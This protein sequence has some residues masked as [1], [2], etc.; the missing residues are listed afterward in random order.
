MKILAVDDA[1]DMRL[2]MQHLLTKLGHDVDTAE[3]GEDAWC[4]LQQN[5]YQVVISDWVMPRVDGLALC[6]RI[7]AAD[8]PHYIYFVLLTGMSGK[9]NLISGIEAGADDFATKPADLE[10]L[11]VR[12]RSAKRVLELESSLAQ[13][14]KSLEAV[15]SIIQKDLENAAA[16]QLSVLPE[17]IVGEK[18]NT[19]W[20]FKPAVFV[21]GDTFN[22]FSIGTD[23]CVFFSIDI[24]G[25]G[26]SA[27]M[28]SMSL[29]S[30]LI[31]TRG[32]YGGPI[33]RDR[34]AEI[35]HIFAKNLNNMM[36][37][38][39]SEHYLTMV[40]GI[41]DFVDQRLHYVQAGHPYPFF[42]HHQSD[43]LETLEVTGFPVGLFEQAEYE[44][45]HMDYAAGDKLILY[46]DGISENNSA[47][48]HEILETDNLHHHFSQI[49]SLPADQMM[50][51]IEKNWLTQQ[52]MEQLPDDISVL[53]FT[54]N[55]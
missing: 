46:S 12:L 51:A 18:L 10:E 2:V 7:R 20:L 44:T 38:N 8:F 19:A 53:I 21:G 24:S 27:A 25:H 29:Q 40:F 35:P 26:V 52:Q 23:L 11:E 45:Q 41:V 13:K 48:N 49:K 34:A 17:P 22:Y 36:L 37:K 30:S 31:Q 39:K 16:T 54:F 6:R 42:Y 4:K 32:L 5:D 33:T 43:T 14:N 50:T 1:R 47:I 9:Q 55:Q 28:V 15:N 3:D